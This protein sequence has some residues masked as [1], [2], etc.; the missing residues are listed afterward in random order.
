MHSF[1]LVMAVVTLAALA[2]SG[3][4]T[5]APQ[6]EPVGTIAF[7]GSD[8]LYL[9]DAGGGKA[10]RIPG[11]LPRDGDPVFSPDGRRIAFD[12]GG[13]DREIWVMDAD[14]SRQRRLTF[15]PGDDGW[16]RWAPHG[17]AVTFE[18]DRDRPGVAAYVVSLESGQARRVAAGAGYPDWRQDGRILFQS[19]EDYD[20]ESVRP[21]GADRRVEAPDTK[22]GRW[23]V[24]ASDDGARIVFT[25]GGNVPRR[26]YTARA[27]RRGSKLVFA[28]RQEIVNP[29][30]SP[31][32]DWITFSMGIGNRLDVY[33]IRADGTGLVRIT[34]GGLA[35]CSDWRP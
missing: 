19:D 15:A 16:P 25:D 8:G 10:R 22:E 29:A 18:S 6:D 35:C 33:V 23:A 34:R 3:G 27:G 28:S 31:D 12:R 5:A 26:L 14:G 17:R 11:T 32:G 20:L 21:Y 13:D 9:V 2:L 30:W 4:A 1:T 24:R 7:E